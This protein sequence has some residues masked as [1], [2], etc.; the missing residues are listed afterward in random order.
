[1]RQTNE[2]MDKLRIAIDKSERVLIQSQSDLMD[3]LRSGTVVAVDAKT[4]KIITSVMGVKLPSPKTA[5]ETALAEGPSK[6]I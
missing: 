1:M 2:E 4:G 6:I 3:L 5:V